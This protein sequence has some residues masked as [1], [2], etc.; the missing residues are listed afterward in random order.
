MK[1]ALLELLDACWANLGP[2]PRLNLVQG[3]IYHLPFRKP[4]FA[5]VYCLGVL[6]HTPDVRRAFLSLP[7]QLQP[8]GRLTVDVYPALLANALWPKY[9]LRP[10]T[11]RLPQARLF[12]LVKLMVRFLLP[13][14]LRVGRIPV[15]G[16][17]LRYAVPVANHEPDFPLSPDQVREWAILNT[18]DMLAPAHDHPQTATTLR[19]WFQEAGL[20]DVQVFRRG[21]LVGRGG[22]AAG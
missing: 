20:V 18:Y 17:K 1:R 14:S 16:R 8:G 10:L 4:S 5:Y 15:V 9:W 12:A 7:E 3:D 13:L 2:H 21:H 11:K 6:Q 22:K 19:R